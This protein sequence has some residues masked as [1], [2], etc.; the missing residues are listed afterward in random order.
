MAKIIE[1]YLEQRRTELTFRGCFLISTP[2]TCHD[3]KDGLTYCWCS[4]SDLCNKVRSQNYHF[5][6]NLH[7][8]FCCSGSIW[9]G[10][11]VADHTRIDIFNPSGL[12]IFCMALVDLSDL[13]QYVEVQKYC[14]SCAMC[15]ENKAKTLNTCFWEFWDYSAFDLWTKVNFTQNTFSWPLTNLLHLAASISHKSGTTR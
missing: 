10:S 11:H 1:L 14:E 6:T 12:S 4:S 13:M 5:Y 15:H 2:D 8:I 7:L 3:A 9:E